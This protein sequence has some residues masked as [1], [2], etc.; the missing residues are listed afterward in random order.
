MAATLSVCIGCDGGAAL[1]DALSASVPINRVVCMNVCTRPA[2]VSL[3]EEGKLA[4]LFGD[5]R[6]DMAPEVHRL[7]ALYDADETGAISDARPLGS[8]RHCLIGR[9]PA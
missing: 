4:Y 6:A 3:R 2:C 1:A 7:L 8:L 9:L 5:V